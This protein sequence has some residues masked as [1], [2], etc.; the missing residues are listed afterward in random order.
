MSAPDEAP[1][2]AVAD[3]PALQRVLGRYDAT[4]IVIGAIIGVG[5]FF[6]P[7]KVA[8]LAGSAEMALL[9][10]GVGGLIALCGALTFAEL[11]ARYPHAGGQYEILRDACGPFPAFLFVFCNATA[12]QAGAI[13][14]IALIC[15]NHLA[16]ALG[17]A[18]LSARG[19]VLAATALIAAVTAANGIGVRFG[20][21]I[22][23]TTV[24]IKVAALLA[25]TLV[26][27]GY[28]GVASPD[29]APGAPVESV[30]QAA[31]DPGA[32]AASAAAPV[33]VLLFSAIVPSFFSYG[34]WQHALW[35]AGEVREPRR[36]LPLAIIVG[37]LVVIATYLAANWA[38]LHLL[39][40]EA[41]TQSGAL[42]ADAVTQ[43][44]PAYGGRLIAAAV[45]VSAFGVL[46]AQLLSG[47]RLI[48]RMAGD[49]RFFRPFA[50]VHPS[51]HTPLAAIVLL[52]GMGLA[53]LLAAAAVSERAIDAVDR[54]TT[55]V[56]FVDGI[57]FALTALSLFVLR[58]RHGQPASPGNAAVVTPRLRLG[59]PV[60]PA[61]FVLG[62]IGIMLGAYADA[63]T[64]GASVIGLLW[65]AVAA[66]VYVLL[67]RANRG[68]AEAV[69]VPQSEA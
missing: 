23:N 13:A 57:F 8:R 59:Y 1:A 48:Y 41:V 4:C 5:I 27:V 69:A 67:F 36:T 60:A 45:G 16:V 52:G 42:A 50:R 24:V 40:Y 21:G 46:N 9:A 14:I 43:V 15:A 22:Q 7:S 28:A 68:A 3:T 38:F 35:I 33:L 47:P 64:R 26:A 53:L 30:V 65:V 49:G 32:Q 37:V 61:I 39:G 51:R 29:A 55:G 34:G 19:A 62:E 20:A 2:L 44:F 63:T 66:I 17:G 58:R 11:G 54:L 31:G 6:T 10:W 56:V 12:V 18:E 25:V